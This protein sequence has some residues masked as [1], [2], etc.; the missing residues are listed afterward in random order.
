M[1]ETELEVW[2]TLGFLRILWATRGGEMSCGSGGFPGER[3]KEM[4]G[5]PK[6]RLVPADGLAVS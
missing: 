2:V 5:P 4:E 1:T 3:W 6:G